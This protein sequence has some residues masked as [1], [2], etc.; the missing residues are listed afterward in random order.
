MPLYRFKFGEF[1]NVQDVYRKYLEVLRETYGDSRADEAA[2][3]YQLI[4]EDSIGDFGGN[5]KHLNNLRGMNFYEEALKALEPLQ[6][7]VLNYHF[8]DPSLLL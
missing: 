7:D 5:M 8:K 2:R 6:R 4:F 1:D 3:R